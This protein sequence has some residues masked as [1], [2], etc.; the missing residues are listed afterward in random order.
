VTRY[1]YLARHGE[2][3]VEDAGLTPTGREQAR[4]LGLRMAAVPLA[5]IHHSPLPRAVQTAELVA[6]ARPDGVP[7]HSTDILG[8]HVP[9]T[10][11]TDAL[12][13]DFATWLARVPDADR[14]AGA[15]L[16]RAATARYAVPADTVTH[17]LIVTHSFVIAW[18]VVHA[19]GAPAERWLGQNHCNC[20]VTAIRYP[21]GRPPALM[22]VNDQT[23]LPPALRWTGFPPELVVP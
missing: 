6:A 20:A 5:A 12:P 11:P 1:L 4:L 16:A 13:P 19:L 9:P 18:F 17:E 10:G 23:H 15:A 7:V 22:V 2:A 21:P 8:D 14:A 3:V